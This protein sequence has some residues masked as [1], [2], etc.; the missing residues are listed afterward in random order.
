MNALRH[1]LLEAFAQF[2]GAFNEPKRSLVRTDD[3]DETGPGDLLGKRSAVIPARLTEHQ[4]AALC[5]NGAGA[6]LA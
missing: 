3:T 5:L 6:R 2:G 4:A 1:R